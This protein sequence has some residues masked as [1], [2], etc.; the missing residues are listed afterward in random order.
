MCPHQG[1]YTLKSNSLPPY[2]TISIKNKDEFSTSHLQTIVWQKMANDE[3]KE[4]KAKERYRRAVSLHIPSKHSLCDVAALSA[5]IQYF[6]IQNQIEVN[7]ME[8][9]RWAESGSTEAITKREMEEVAKK[10]NP[11]M[12]W[13]LRRFMEDSNLSKWCF[14]VFGCDDHLVAIYSSMIR[15]IP[16]Y[17]PEKG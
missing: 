14:P 13:T 12:T 4:E 3:E 16:K 11:S 5:C 1:L 10:Y 7:F 17:T 8:L 6:R 9:K 15:R 2:L